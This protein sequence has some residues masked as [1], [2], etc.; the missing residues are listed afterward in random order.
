MRL[1]ILS[2]SRIRGGAEEYALTIAR[3]ASKQGWQVHVAFERTAHNSSLIHDFQSSDMHYHHLNIGESGEPAFEPKHKHFLRFLRTLFL[4]HKLEPEVVQIVLPWPTYGQGAILACGLLKVPTL[5]VFQ[6]AALPFN[7]GKRRLQ[8]LAWARSRN[9]QW[10]AVSRHNRRIIC[11]VFRISEDDVLCIYNGAKVITG[12]C[13]NSS[14][15]KLRLDMRSKLELPSVSRIILTV[16]RLHHQKGYEDLIPVIPHIVDEFPN[17]YFVWA[18]DGELRDHLR[19]L[20]EEYGVIQRVRML[21]HRS[22]VRDLLRAS[23]LFVLP[24]HFEGQSFA[25]AEA[26][27]LGIPVVV[28]NAS[29]IPEVIEHRVHGLLFRVG[30]SCDLLESIRWALRNPEK[31]SEMGRNAQI[32]A[33]EF[34]EEKMILATLDALQ[35]LGARRE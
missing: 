13:D 11:N 12:D 4:L 14:K 5:V 19:N 8:L 25:L 34:S 22:D 23:D 15:H 32:R 6:L 20:L 24:T 16:G 35:K 17:V 33:R 28:S 30:D 26:M 27:G 10:V 29:G 1:L 18:G 31:M 9:Q 21:G 7:I 2:P 3:A